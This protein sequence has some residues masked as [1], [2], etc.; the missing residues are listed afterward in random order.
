MSNILELSFNGF[1]FFFCKYFALGT[2][3]PGKKLVSKSQQH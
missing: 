1:F 3:Q 2:E